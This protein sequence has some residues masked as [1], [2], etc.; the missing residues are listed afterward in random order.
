[1]GKTIGLVGESNDTAHLQIIMGRIGLFCI[2]WIVV[3][4]IAQIIV[5]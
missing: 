4:L 1:M 5:M 3:F 2:G